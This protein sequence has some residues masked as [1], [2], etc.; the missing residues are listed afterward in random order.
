LQACSNLGSQLLTIHN[1]QQEAY[2]ESFIYN[3]QIGSQNSLT[4]SGLHY[5]F[6]DW[7]WSDGTSLGY[8]DWLSGQPSIAGD[9]AAIQSYGAPTGWKVVDCNTV[10]PYVCYHNALSS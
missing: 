4:W 7:G 5:Q 6:D 1:S 8:T 2:V 3:A 10:L 9:C